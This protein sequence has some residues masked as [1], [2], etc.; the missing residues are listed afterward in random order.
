MAMAVYAKD[1]RN[2]VNSLWR[3]ACRAHLEG[4]F[5]DAAKAY[6]GVL[7][8]VPK[9]RAVAAKAALMAHHF[10]R[11]DEAK[12]LLAYY[13]EGFPDDGDQWYNL[14]KFRHDLGELEEAVA[15]YQHALILK[16]TVEAMSNLGLCYA[17]LGRPEDAE[18]AFSEALAMNAESAEAR[19][20]RA[21]VRLSRG[22]YSG[23]KDYEARFDCASFQ[24]SHER[25]DLTGPRWTGETLWPGAA[26]LVHSEQGFGDVIQFARFVPEVRARVPEARV[27]LEVPAE[28]LRLFRSAWPDLEIVPRG[29]PRT[30]YD[31]T[32]SILSLPAI[33][34]VGIDTI[35][36]PVPFG[37]VDTHLDLEALVAAA[38]DRPRVGICWAGGKAHPTDHR[39]SL[40]DEAARALF[41]SVDGVAWYSL[42]VGEREDRFVD[43]APELPAGSSL[44]FA[45]KAFRDFGDT[46]ALMRRLDLVI[47]VDTAT[48]HLAGSL[49]VPTWIMLPTPAEW[50][51]MQRLEVSPWYPSATLI[52]QG[53][54]RRWDDV[55]DR[56]AL[57]LSEV[58]R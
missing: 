10:R 9:E 4:K 2:Q 3:Q 12:R 57:A 18:E 28:L 21:F 32:V 43:E 6:Q 46:A 14:A 13:L 45:R 8:L 41:K 22:D 11:H 56:I 33:M 51:W 5:A 19:F 7:E 58:A 35:P 15:H 29:M 52:R 38:G 31:A 17:E 48:A 53:T 39:R 25:V 16:P 1:V 49:G 26:L 42:Q 54:P 34:G 36:A 44:L 20:N 27:T 47:A 24:W 23:W 50:R 30:D 37:E 55:L 40:P